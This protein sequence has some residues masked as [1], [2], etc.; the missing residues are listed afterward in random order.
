MDPELGR[1]GES[2]SDTR[3]R[4]PFHTFLTHRQPQNVVGRGQGK[5]EPLGVVAHS[6]EDRHTHVSPGRSG[7]AACFG[8]SQP[9]WM[10][11][12][13]PGLLPVHLT[14]LSSSRSRYFSLGSR[15]VTFGRRDFRTKYEPRARPSRVSSP[16]P[17][18]AS[19]TGLC[20]WRRRR[21]H[22]AG[23]EPGKWVVTVPYDQPPQGWQSRAPAREHIMAE[24]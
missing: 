4:S 7:A 1:E 15:R 23:E 12:P 13:L 2:L 9:Q 10:V 8:A 3:E 17:R 5:A 20:G 19:R 22:H 14:V 21:D 6:L 11:P 18:E 16:T 24:G